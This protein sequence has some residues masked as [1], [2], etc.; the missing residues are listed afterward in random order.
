[1]K[2][3]LLILLFGTSLKEGNVPLKI[4]KL[5]TIEDKKNIQCLADA[6]YQ[7]SG[8]QIEEGRKAVA[9]VIFNRA[10]K[11]KQTVCEVIHQPHQFVWT[12]RPTNLEIYKACE[13]LAYNMYLYRESYFD[14]TKNS[15]FFHA[16]YINPHWKNYERT[17]RIQ[18]HIFYRLKP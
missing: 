4:H 8:N 13:D 18:D 6:I 12:I 9:F 15:L 7:E 17:V 1:M 10:V 5:V 2:V 3:L 16:Y 11:Y 14:N